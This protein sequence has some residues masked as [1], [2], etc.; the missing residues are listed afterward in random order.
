MSA[1]NAEGG[2]STTITTNRTL[3]AQEQQSPDW[4]TEHIK[5][6]TTSTTQRSMKL[7]IWRQRATAYRFVSESACGTVMLE[8][9]DLPKRS[10]C[11]VVMLTEAHLTKR[12]RKLSVI[13]LYPSWIIMLCLPKCRSTSPALAHL[14]ARLGRSPPS[15]PGPCR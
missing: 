9:K 6:L 8:P 10:E 2:K 11:L 4:N 14:R 15:G 5:A 3:S 7:G 12:Y 1:T 13:S